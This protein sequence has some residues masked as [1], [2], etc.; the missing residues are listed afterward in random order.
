MQINNFR[1]FSSNN[2]YNNQNQGNGY[3]LFNQFNNQRNQNQNNLFFSNSNN[4]V[5]FINSLQNTNNFP[6]RINPLSSFQMPNSSSPPAKSSLTKK[7]LYVKLTQEEKGY[8]SNLFQLVDSQGMGKIKNKDAANFMKK[9]G[10]NRNIL[11]NIFLIAQPK[12]KQYLERDEFYVALRLI[13]LAQNNMPFNEQAIILNK[14]LPPL[15]NFNLKKDFFADGDSSFELKD[16]E[17]VKYKRIF[18]I[19]KDGNYDNISTKKA[20]QMWRSIGVNDNVIQKVADVLKPN[21]TRGFLNLREFQVATHLIN[22]SERHEIPTQLPESLKKY[23]GRD[24]INNN[25]LKLNFENDLV[26][27]NPNNN[28]Q[29]AIHYGPNIFSNN[30]FNNFSN[31]FNNKNFND[32][33]FNNNNFNNNNFNNNNFNNNNFNNNNFNNNNFN[34]DLVVKNQNSN[35]IDILYQKNELLNNKIN[36]ARNK[37]NNILKEID[38]M[39][40]EQLNI[41]SQINMLKDK[42][43]NMQSNIPNI[44]INNNTNNININ[45]NTNNIN[46]SGNNNYNIN[47]NQSG[48]GP[49]KNIIDFNPINLPQNTKENKKDEYEK[50]VQKKNSLLDLMNKM[51]LDKIAI[52][53]DLNKED[54]KNIQDEHNKDKV[55]SPLEKD[56]PPNNIP[57][58]DQF[59]KTNSNKFDDK[60]LESQAF[61]PEK[62]EKLAIDDISGTDD[63]N[64]NFEQEENK[65]NNDKKRD[66]I[67]FGMDSPIENKKFN[68]ENKYSNISLGSEIKKI[69]QNEYPNF[70]ETNKINNNDSKM[71]HFE[72]GDENNRKSE[73][74]ES[75]D[76][77]TFNF[78]T[79]VNQKEG[80]EWDF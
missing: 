36:N 37:L 13:A 57:H 41:K 10:L 3:Q 64:I 75:L 23:L 27:K 4:N 74:K 39:Q 56:N 6:I 55:D 80:D 61:A 15:P 29:L 26:N 44:N 76:K 40:N 58:L 25:I 22:L 32:N 8:Y 51:Q 60:L 20:I 54:S 70:D 79:T 47:L 14:P 46:N 35:S 31:N 34:Q 19:N 2:R 28:Q 50:L 11:K 12:S 9:S 68:F 73:R 65:A 52:N 63:F 72:F 45:N 17:K 33:N 1:G 16:D 43:I 30:N 66:S 53:N 62:L 67:N 38:D 18:D 7:R 5:P 69:E 21:E 24:S 78:N 71:F 77:D 49:S 48:I 59:N 42:N